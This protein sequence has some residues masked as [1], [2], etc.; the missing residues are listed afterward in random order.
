[1]SVTFERTNS[2]REGRE[3]NFQAEKK[4]HENQKIQ[5]TRRVYLP[6]IACMV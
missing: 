4:K 1:M 6:I 5:N 2:A 3:I